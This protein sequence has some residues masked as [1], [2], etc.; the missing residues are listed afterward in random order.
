[1]P[2]NPAQVRAVLV[3]MKR[4]LILLFVVLS[5]F[6]AAYALKSRSQEHFE[7]ISTTLQ[8]TDFRTTPPKIV[9]VLGRPS[10]PKMCTI[11]V[12]G[13]FRSI[14]VITA[15]YHDQINLINRMLPALLEQQTSGKPTAEMIISQ[16]S[17]SYRRLLSEHQSPEAS[18][19]L[20]K[21]GNNLPSLNGLP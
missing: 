7:A 15:Q 14:D 3:A 8:W 21:V 6:F 2:I 1:M 4:N 16:G 9:R 19:L 13:K 5:V 12:G 20:D 10:G 17:S 11:R 18:E